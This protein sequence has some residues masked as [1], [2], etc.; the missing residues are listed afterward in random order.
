[1]DL[2]E[3]QLAEKEDAEDDDEEQ[4]TTPAPVEDFDASKCGVL[5][6]TVT[7][8]PDE[9]PID[10]GVSFLMK[11]NPPPPGDKEP[12]LQRRAMTFEGSFE[13]PAMAET[14]ASLRACSHS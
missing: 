13:L 10:Q 3:Q 2:L 11:I 7:M 4:T 1:M 8:A 5:N 14:V 9:I 12:A 6:H